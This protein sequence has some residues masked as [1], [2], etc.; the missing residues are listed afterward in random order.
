M[1][2]YEYKCGSCGKEFE[3]IVQGENQ[4]SCEECGSSK[5]SKKLSVFAVGKGSAGSPECAP[6]CGEGFQKGTCGSESAAISATYPKI[7]VTLLNVTIFRA[8]R[9]GR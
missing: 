7:V 8:E 5:V 1:P 4:V 3:V 9:L 2:I 6:R